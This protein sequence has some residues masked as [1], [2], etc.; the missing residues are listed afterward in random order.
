MFGR[1]LTLRAG[2]LLTCTLEEPNF[3]SATT[4]VGK[5]TVCYLFQMREFGHAAFP[6]GSYLS[7][8]LVGKGWLSL[9]FDRLILPDTDIPIRARFGFRVDSGGHI[10]G[11]GHA[12]RNAFTPIL[13]PIKLLRP[14]SGSAGRSA[15]HSAS[16][17]RR[18]A[19]M[20]RTRKKQPLRLSKGC[21][22]LESL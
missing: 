13:W 11:R 18:D 14:P 6:R 16:A 20:L 8:R 22:T 4:E 15:D 3:S 7:G 17:R 2:E 21:F 12:S 5:T 19:A 9:Q 1:E 10:E